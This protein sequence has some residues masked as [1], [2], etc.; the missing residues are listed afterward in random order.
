MLPK[1]AVTTIQTNLVWENKSANLSLLEEK[2][3]GLQQAEVV[4]LP[5]MFST[6]FSMQP[7]VFAEPMDG[8]TVQWMQRISQAKNVVLTG[9]LMIAADGHFY[10]RMLWVLP[11]GQM[12][13]YDKRHL[14]SMAGEQ[15]HYTSGQR[16]LI[17]SVKGWRMLL[18]VCYDLRFPVW[19]RQQM[20]QDGAAEFDAIIYVANWPERRA[21]AWKT[22]LQARAIEN[23]CFTIGVNRIGED[24]NE[25]YH[26][27]DSSIFDPAGHMLYQCAHKEDIH[28]EWLDGAQ[29]QDIRERLP[30]LQDADRFHIAG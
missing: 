2:I 10:N 17:V 20:Q 22:L 16:R 12:G 4:V 7:E 15:Q 9:S 26:S 8:Q 11:N 5:E 30:F 18:Q 3:M 21:M 13:F 14:F 28:T 19:T 23:Q 25:V 29:L 6:G 27:G 24:G 1:L